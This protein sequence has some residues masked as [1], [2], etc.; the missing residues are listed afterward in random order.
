MKIKKVLTAALAGALCLTALSACGGSKQS[1]AS[2]KKAGKIVMYTNAA[3]PPFEYVEN[4]KVVGVDADIAQAVA[5]DIGVTLEIQNVEFTSVLASISS[6]K[7]AFAAAGLSITPERKEQVDFSKSYVTSEQ[8]MIVPE[9]TEV[10]AFEDMAGFRIGVQDG[11]T[12]FYYVA[13]EVD[14]YKD[15][16]DQAV[17][18]VLQ[19]TGASYKAYSNAMAAV[20]DMQADRLDAVVIDKLPAETIVKNNT[21][22][23][24]I[25][26]VYADGTT[27][28]EEYAIA[29]QKGNSELLAQIDK[30]I[31][32]LISEGKIDEF[33]VNHG[34]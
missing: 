2:I 10:A 24:C 3:F 20:Q 15:D 6:G 11:T 14:G 4:E 7:G 30:T 22:L 8:Y 28:Q 33:L 34:A 16:N 18:G 21:G 25:P 26:L 27:T 29:V 32:R 19:D 31:D 5:D 13:D 1:L 9:A 23:K 12:G 17:K